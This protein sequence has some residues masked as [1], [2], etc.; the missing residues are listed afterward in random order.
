MDLILHVHLECVYTRGGEA[1]VQPVPDS[2]IQAEDGDL[3]KATARWEK[4]L[5]WR[6]DNDVDNILSVSIC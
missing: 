6:K 4:T 3:E 1:P 5:Q 2:F